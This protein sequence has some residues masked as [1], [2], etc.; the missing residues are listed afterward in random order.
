MEHDVGRGFRRV[1]T[2]DIEPVTLRG[3]RIATRRDRMLQGDV[4]SNFSRSARQ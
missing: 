3:S 2:V 4:A 1:A